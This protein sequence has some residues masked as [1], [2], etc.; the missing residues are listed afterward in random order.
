MHNTHT[1]P[2]E[3]SKKVSFTSSRMKNE[4]VS[5]AHNFCIFFVISNG[6]I[7]KVF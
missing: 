2:C 1:V 4:Y 6:L 5:A 7:T 3:K